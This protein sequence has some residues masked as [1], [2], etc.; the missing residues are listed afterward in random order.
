MLR[1]D[2]GNEHGIVRAVQ[3]GGWIGEQTYKDGVSHG[4]YRAVRRDIIM[5]YLYKNGEAI[6]WF[7]FKIKADGEFDEVEREDAKLYFKDITP[8]YFMKESKSKEESKS[9]N[10]NTMW[11]GVDLSK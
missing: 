7:S 5:I 6:A 9:A 1:K 4:L 3:E 11:F 10:K 2:T 8:K